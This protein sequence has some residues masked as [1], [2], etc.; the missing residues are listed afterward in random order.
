M[1]TEDL[2]VFFSESEFA[3]AVTLNGVS[4]LAIFDAGYSAGN[5]GAMGMAS[6]QPTLT[7][8][9]ASVPANP[10]G[11]SAVAAAV[12]YT[13]AAHEPDGTGVSVLYLERT[14]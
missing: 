1:F 7:L 2:S 13:I 10:V 14:T 5:V 12:T 3:S 9:T 6:T 8:A 4:A 11:L